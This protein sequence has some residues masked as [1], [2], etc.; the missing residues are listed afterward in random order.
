MNTTNTWICDTCGEPIEKASDGWVE[1]L[2]ERVDD[3]KWIGR[4]LR[5]VHHYPASARG[6]DSRCQYHGEAEYKRNQSIVNDQSLEDFLGP[7]GLMQLLSFIADGKIPT[8]EV[9]E[10]IKRL[11]IPG[12]EHA[13]LHF[14]AA[15]AEVAFEPNTLKDYYWQSDISAVLEF[16][17]RQHDT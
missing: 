6:S 3:D 8:V 9:L 2:M 4:G 16:A 5:L 11:H 14:S 1:W 12:Y 10:M 15:L 17:N 13:R 7:D